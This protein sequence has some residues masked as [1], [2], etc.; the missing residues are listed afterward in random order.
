MTM[1]MMMQEDL[2]WGMMLVVAGLTEE[3]FSLINDDAGPT[4]PLPS[5]PFSGHS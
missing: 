3:A 4:E 1:V 5:R 2:W